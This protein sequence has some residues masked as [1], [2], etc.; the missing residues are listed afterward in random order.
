MNTKAGYAT[1]LGL[2]NAGKSTLL[3]ALLGQ[4]ISII[5]NKPQTTRKR[6]L[7]I[8][9][10][11]NYQVIFLDTPGILKPAY[12]L[13]QKM[14]DAVVTS[15]TDAD[16]I[17]LIMDVALDPTGEDTLK[18]AFIYE[19]LSKSKKPKILLLNKIDL[20]TQE[21]V[22]ELII[23]V[24]KTNYFK[25]IIPISSKQAYNVH[26]VVN[27]IVECLPEGPKF[28]PDD[29]VAD[30]NE[31]F[32]VSE[33]I[34]EKIFEFY[35]DEIPYSS[36]VIIVD[37]KE[38][39]GRKDF[40]QAEII[41]ERDSQKGILIGKEGAALKRVGETARKSIEE[42]LDRPVYLDLRVRVREKWRSDE[43]MLKSF[44]YSSEKE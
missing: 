13:Q 5:T 39:E 35:K 22:S 33:I 29:I 18:D 10:D 12:L 24:E 6:I 21:Q 11:D 31:R 3:N 8:L 15:V 30:E 26:S 16:V 40:I 14:M 34:R 9:S 32:F 23:K 27:E 41:V 1:I 36:E 28:Y 44:G 38:R 25:K 37:F 42:F 17:L 2:P 7:G 43:K 4:K 20:S 19:L